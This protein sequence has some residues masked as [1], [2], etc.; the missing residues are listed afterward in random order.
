VIA[1]SLR[2]GL[3]S[4]C[5]CALQLAGCGGSEVPFASGAPG[6]AARVAF[7]QSQTRTVFPDGSA[8]FTV[9]PALAGSEQAVCAVN[10]V[11]V[12]SCMED[13]DSGAIPYADLRPGIHELSVE[14]QAADGSTDER[15][16]RSLEVAVASVV[17]Y[18][19][20]PGGI[21]AAIAAARAGQT[22]AVLERTRWIGG[23]M[24]GGLARTDVGARGEEIIGGLTAE[25][26]ERIRDAENARNACPG[27]Q[28]C[29]GLHR[30]EPQVA[31]RVFEEMIAESGVIL[32]RSARLTGVLSGDAVIR[33]VETTR[34]EVAG[35]VFIDA[36]YE[37]DLMAM[38]GVAYR[39]GREPR[40]MADPPDD[41]IQLSIQEDHAGATEYRVPQGVFVDPY[42][43]PGEPA[44]GTLPFVEPRP[45][46]LPEEGEGDSRV[47]A[48][49]YRLC[50]TD[51]PSNRIPFERPENYDPA[52]YE[53]SA[54]VAEARVQQGDVNLAEAMFNPAVTLLSRDPAYSKY[55]LNGGGTFSSDM[56]A[57]DLNQL[58]V[59]ADEAERERIRAAYRDYV[60]GLL[61]SWR[62]DP[63][64][65][66]LNEKVARF[67]LC[68]DEFVD[69][70]GWPHQL[71][72]RAA[73]R[74]VGAYVMN[75][76]DVLQNGRRPPIS[77]P[78]GFGAYSMD[79]HTTRY[80]AAP[81]RWPGGATKDALVVEGFQVVRIPEFE[82]YPVPYRA[83]VPR[84][85][86]ATN[87]L[88]P[89]TL[90]ATHMAYS[91][92]RMEPTF[93]ILG[94]AAGTAAAL[95]I[96]T[97]ESVQSVDYGMLRQRLLANGAI[98]AN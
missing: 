91:S 1:E 29:R 40:R 14:I 36:S 69:S 85:E 58:Y 84:A 13:A 82:P 31:A 96:E 97:Q 16:V 79:S 47:M 68:A 81:V 3:F 43:I 57:P 48:Y 41:A 52:Q 75:E 30:L 70:G 35:E 26:F 67:G 90:S 33:A 20:T 22:V 59:E 64:F 4:S 86:D 28:R 27:R 72:V 42:R 21:S 93:M 50:V 77:D 44:S 60:R 83:L 2:K 38:A 71:Y 78:V 76:N 54:R 94:E 61:Y 51:D 45:E 89:V 55:D 74:M 53:A 24:S 73:R 5:L 34:G 56:T 17:V 25:Y 9:S 92:L 10:D 6:E 18:G 49:T 37:G 46:I 95:A 32:E 63:R 87:L 65:G 39:V 12:D 66:T 11:T 88:N 15:A 7:E 23:M 62:T 8:A 98:L 80:F 19:A